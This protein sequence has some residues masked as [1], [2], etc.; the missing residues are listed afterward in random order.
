M[1]MAV[2]TD[3][4]VGSSVPSLL[5]LALAVDFKPEHKEFSF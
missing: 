4:M 2:W 5:V 3:E 1:L